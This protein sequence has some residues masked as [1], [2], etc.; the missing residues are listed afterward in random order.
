MQWIIPALVLS[1]AA[2]AERPPAQLY[3]EYC[4]SCHAPQW[5]GH[6]PATGAMRLMSPDRIFGSML[7]GS[8]RQA[9]AEM[10][11]TEKQ[12]VAEW[13]AGREVGSPPWTLRLDYV[14]SGSAAG[15]EFRRDGLWREGPW[16]GPKGKREDTLGFGKYRFVVRRLS[17]GMLVYSRGFSSIFGEWETTPDAKTNTAEFHESARFPMPEAPVRLTIEKRDAANRFQPVWSSELRPDEAQ[18]VAR[19]T[20]PVVWAVLENGPSEKKVDLLLAGDGYTEA[21]M[22]KWRGDARRAAEAL[23]RESPFRERRSSFNVWAADVPARRSGVSRPSDGVVHDSPWGAAYD[24]FGSE[25]YVLVFDNKRL[26]DLAGAA[27]YEFLIVLVNDRKYG[28]GGIYQ[29]YATA[30]AGNAFRDY[31]VVH[32]FGHHF[33]GLADEYYTSDVAYQA[34]PNAPEPWEANVTRDPRA[35][36]WAPL[37]SPGV[38]LPTPW[39]KKEFEERQNRVQAERRQLRAQRAPEEQMESLFRRE[40]EWTT[41]LLAPLRGK[42]GAFEGANYSSTGFYRPQADCLMFTRDNAGFCAVCRRALEKVIDLYT[43]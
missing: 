33:A 32:E 3:Q 28:G 18:P 22:D 2:G 5:A 35:A 20:Q 21:E 6:A 15:E 43:E 34:D 31:L 42:V 13:L 26:R 8:M 12:A 25:R 10:S 9:A 1:V 16:P 19:A 38:R 7:T 41:K 4:A 37:L 29:L 23:F 40:L 14:H 30:A 39:P 27:P 36:K 11:D 17:D 24:A